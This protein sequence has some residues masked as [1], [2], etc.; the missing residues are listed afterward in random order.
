[1]PTALVLH[2]LQRASVPQLQR[3]EA[4]NPQLSAEDLDGLWK[5][6]CLRIHPFIK[7]E[8]QKPE[9]LMWRELYTD[10][11]RA[12]REK[13]ASFGKRFREKRQREEEEKRESSV[14]LLSQAV[15]KKKMKTLGSG[16]A[17]PKRMAQRNDLFADAKRQAVKKQQMLH[18]PSA[19]E[20]KRK[21]S[22]SQP[23]P[24]RSHS[25]PLQP[26]A[27]GR[28]AGSGLPSSSHHPYRR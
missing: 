21:L 1:M 10:A 13:M 18:V 4:M 27:L 12:E 20:I 24:V 7:T 11:E 15:V 14:K 23:G 9:G 6:H 25:S 19:A 28:R 16:P 22:H 3:V 2:I 17:A 5:R 8:L 26:M